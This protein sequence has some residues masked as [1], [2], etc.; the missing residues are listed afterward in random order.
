MYAVPAAYRDS[1]RNGTCK[2]GIVY[3]VAH[4]D[5]VNG[6]LV[7]GVKAVL[8]KTQNRIRAQVYCVKQKKRLDFKKIMLKA[9]ACCGKQ[10][11]FNG[12]VEIVI[13]W[14]FIARQK[15]QAE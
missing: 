13:D 14:E 5:I 9:L 15:K 8:L 11:P 3:K 10:S 1:P 2:R 4:H 12:G 7:K 6:K